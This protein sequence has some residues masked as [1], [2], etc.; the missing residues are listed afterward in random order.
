MIF[1]LR[2]SGLPCLA[3]REVWAKAQC[4]QLKKNNIA[5]EGNTLP[6]AILLVAPSL[7]GV[8]LRE[9]WAEAGV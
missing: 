2:R 1:Y 8:A 6:S 9:A 7:P 4:C 5:C 3:L